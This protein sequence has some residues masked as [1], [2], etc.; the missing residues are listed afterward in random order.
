MNLPLAPRHK[1]EMSD[2]K[3]SWKSALLAIAVVGAAAGGGWMLLMSGPSTAPEEEARPPK[4]VKT[5]VVTASSHA[6]SVDVSGSVIASRKVVIEPEVTGPVIRQHAQLS[7]GGIILEGEELLAIDPTL[8]RLSLEEAKAAVARSEAEL[9]ESTRKRDE[10]MRLTSETL[11]SKTELAALEADLESE[12]ADLRRLKAAEERAEELLRRHS[13]VAPFNALVLDEAVEVGQRVDSG[14][15]A[16]TLVGSDEFWAQA[17]LPIDQ[18]RH[19]RLPVGDEPGSRADVYLDTGD[20][21]RAHRPGHVIRLL[22]EMERT[23]RLARVL[24]RIEDPLGLK[25][26]G[27]TTPFLLGSYVQIKIDAGRLDGVLAINRAA[28]RDGNRV[29]VVDEQSELQIKDVEVVRQE[30]ETVFIKNAIAEGEA[31]IVSPLK[32]ALPGMK[33]KAQPVEPP[34]TTAKPLSAGESG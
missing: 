4:I 19:V 17:A 20:G 14:F 8:A 16:A 34:A 32:L 31:L 22:G 9:K 25:A 6:I 13:I 12:V 7:P 33:V 30:N 29:W 24:I 3:G 10:A 26:G 23:G 1:S 11:L 18:L 21:K 27:P 15:A 2:E 28:L 5:L